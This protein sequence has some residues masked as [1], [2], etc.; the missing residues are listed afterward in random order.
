MLNKEASRFLKRQSVMAILADKVLTEAHYTRLNDLFTKFRCKELENMHTTIAKFVLYDLNNYKGRL[1][2][3]LGIPGTSKYTQLLRYGKNNVEKILVE[4]STR[5]TRHFPNTV[6]YWLEKG[7]SI[8]QAKIEVSKCQSVRSVLSPASQKGASEYSKRCIGFWIKKGLSEEDAKKEVANFQRRQHSEER[9]IKW[10]NT[11]NSKSDAERKL[12]NQKKGHSID[13]YVLKGFSLN[14]ATEKSNAYYAKRNNYSKSSQVFFE[15]LSMS[16]GHSECYFKTKNYEKQFN[17]KC[18][19][20]YDAKSNVVIEYYGDFWHRNP[21]KYSSEFV[22]YNKSSAQIW[23]EDSDRIEKIRLAGVKKVIIVWESEVQ[24]N[25]QESVNKI[26]GEIN[27][28]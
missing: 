14:D 4:Q 21:T 5:K 26:L 17:G 6:N 8:N 12:I 3:L 22:A 7:L 20:F 19:D 27:G 13:A 18:V 23:K 24:V 15:L 10:Q 9:N 2:R 28:N 11:L 1:R 25:P 16:L